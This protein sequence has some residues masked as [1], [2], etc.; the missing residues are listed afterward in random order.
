[1]SEVFGALQEFASN[2]QLYDATFERKAM[3][4]NVAFAT[5]SDPRLP[6]RRRFD[7]R[8]E[9]VIVEVGDTSEK[10]TVHHPVLC[11]S[12]RFLEAKLKPQWSPHN[13]NDCK[14]CLILLPEQDPE[15][16]NLYVNWL[17]MAG[18]PLAD[19][20]NDDDEAHY[21]DWLQLAAAYVLGEAL[22]DPLFQHDVLDAMRAKLLSRKGET[23]HIVVA[24]MVWLIC[25]GTLEDSPARRFLVD[26]FLCGSPNNRLSPVV[27]AND[28][29]TN[30]VHEVKC[31]QARTGERAFFDVMKTMPKPAWTNAS[32][33]FL[34]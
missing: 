6:M 29:P 28:L 4:T 16:F 5:P 32:I 26:V 34:L 10:F 2:F 31:A 22:I 13:A 15:A 7:A 12:S 24:D 1:M 25:D 20:S 23:I 9:L 21:E 11:K 18:L 30:F 17:Y 8:Q 27:L 19:P 3:D 14:A 33:P